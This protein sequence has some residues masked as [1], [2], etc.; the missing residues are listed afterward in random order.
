RD[1]KAERPMHAGDV[2]VLVQT[3]G[4]FVEHFVRA[5]KRAAVP[6]SGVDRMMLTQQLAVMDVMALLQFALLP[7]DHLTLACV[8]RGPFIGASE[9]QLMDLAIERQGSL[10]QSLCEKASSCAEYALWRDYLGTLLDHADQTP[11]LPLLVGVLNRACPA[12]ARS[13]R[14]AIAA[15]LGPD[16]EDPLDELL[17]AAEAFGATH[18]P[19]LQSFL[20]WLDSTEAM[21]KREMEQAVHRVRITTVHASKG[22]ESPIVILPDTVR[23][24]DK[25]KLSKIAWD[26]DSNLPFY[27]PREPANAFLR[28]LRG[29]A[30]ARQLEEY[31]RLLYVAMTRAADRLYVCG[32]VKEKA[33]E[34]KENWYN[35]IA[36]GLTP[37]HQQEAVAAEGSA[38]APSIVVA[39]YARQHT[40]S[41]REGFTEACS[42]PS[43]AIQICTQ[44]SVLVDGVS[45]GL[46]PP[47]ND[48]RK[49]YALPTWLF[50]P[51]P[52]E[53]SPPRPLVPS[54]PSEEDP[55][56]ISPKDARFA[57]GR[58]IHRLLQNLPEIEVSLW[59]RAVCRF[60][61]NPQ[62]GLHEIEQHEIGKE[63]LNLLHDP[64]FAPLFGATS[65]AEQP[66]VGLSGE[67]LIAGQVDRLAL[68]DGEVWIVDYKTNRPPPNDAAQI[69][70]VYKNQMEAYRT[71]LQAIYPACKVRCFLLW[72]YT[73]RLMEVV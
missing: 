68:V 32:F 61:A 66:I 24:P 67:R 11:P 46:K 50:A 9:E 28:G 40:I 3:R 69:P 48:G 57:R 33:D 70:S 13:G 41:H 23:V 56:A 17:N 10:W 6:V 71:V 58:L 45:R 44:A 52:P 55:P 2:M 62:H 49:T 5:L 63:V 22:L 47:R 8:L 51:P 29:R 15:R 54:R 38:L 16:A 26:S 19:S 39:D 65:R 42:D 53:P 60:L 30:Y 21:I 7:E 72:T 1:L 37:L 34:G 25:N 20:H 14:C 31:R 35:L 18:T 27:V 36:Q 12:D 59:E 43:P 64:H 4:A 73:L